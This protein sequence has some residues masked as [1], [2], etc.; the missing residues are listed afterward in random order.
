MKKIS[1]LFC[2]LLV[3]LATQSFA[4]ATLSIQGVIRNSDG[5]AVENGNYSIEFRL[6]N[7]DSGGSPIWSETQNN[8]PVTGGIYSALLGESEDLTAAFDETYYLGVSIDGGTELTPRARLTSSPYALSLIGNSNKF[9]SD[10][11]VGVGTVNPEEKL[12]VVGKGKF[13]DGLDVTGNMDI[14]GDINFT[15]GGISDLILSGD[16]EISGPVSFSSSTEASL[17]NGAIVFGQANNKNIVIDSDE[18]QA[19]NN[20]NTN[21]LDLNPAGGE[22]QV[23]NKPIP[24][25]EENLRIIRGSVN[26][27]GIKITGSGFNSS[28]STTGEYTISFSSSFSGTPVITSGNHEVNRNVAT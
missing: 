16:T 4:Q 26:P 19:R 13:T 6:Y 18:I 2:I 24:V 14:E 27:S 1:L 15:N 9:S 12:H 28:K 11:N 21:I 7:T 25:A 23:N 17:S 20:G 8:V 10:G 3:A 22:V 5:S